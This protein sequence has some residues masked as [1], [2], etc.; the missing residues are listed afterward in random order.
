M[1]VREYLLSRNH[2][3]DPP[4][5]LRELRGLPISKVRVKDGTAVEGGVELWLITRHEDV[6]AV[7]R[8]PRFSS[9]AGY[10]KL[11]SEES[12]KLNAWHYTSSLGHMDGE[13]HARIRQALA[14]GFLP[15]S[16]EALRPK[17]EQVIDTRIDLLLESGPPVDL[18][19]R[20]S[21]PVA[22]KVVVAAMGMPDAFQRAVEDD[23]MKILDSLLEE[24]TPQI[25]EKYTAALVGLY[26]LCEQLLREH[27]DTSNSLF[28]QIQRAV[29]SDQLSYHEACGVITNVSAI[30]HPISASSITLS[31]LML[32]LN[33]DLGRAIRDKD[34][35]AYVV[36][37][38][39]LRYHSPMNWG[40]PRVATE[41][42]VMNGVLIRKG[43]GVMVSLPSANRDEA[44]FREPDQLDAT[45]SGVRQHVT[46]G[47]GPHVCLGQWLARAEVEISVQ[48]LMTRIP[49]L[50]LAVPPEELSFAEDAYIFSVDELPVA[51]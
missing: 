29:R 11:T 26:H 37:E 27:E 12:K 15:R 34:A 31:T 40:L 5:L 32:L 18:H 44:V 14:E 36:L 3:F 51:W 10:T 42:V 2:P 8:D 45:R 21:M 39:L 49:S 16:I 6:L 7:L 13:K 20:F 24:S 46:F 48:A 41:D 47:G 38:E 25:Q 1:A 17:L 4:E 22:G 30:G 19:K 23:Y 33:P 35:N 9:A 28:A 50:R 43:D